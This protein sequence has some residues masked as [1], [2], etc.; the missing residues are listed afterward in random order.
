MG[1]SGDS[2][3][4]KSLSLEAGRQLRVIT[5]RYC[6]YVYIYIGLVC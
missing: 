1:H 2:L 3:K 6:H 5:Q 4:R